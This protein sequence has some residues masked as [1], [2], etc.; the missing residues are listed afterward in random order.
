ME[1]ELV[2]VSQGEILF[3][4]GLSVAIGNV[5]SVAFFLLL[6]RARGSRCLGIEKKKTSLS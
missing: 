1:K 6:T 3:T 2:R 4:S 5:S